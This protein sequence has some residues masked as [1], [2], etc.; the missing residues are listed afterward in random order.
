MFYAP[1]KV[2]FFSEEEQ[3]SFASILNSY[4]K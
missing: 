4:L 2:N 1:I 3:E